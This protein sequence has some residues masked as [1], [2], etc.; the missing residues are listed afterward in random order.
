MALKI[1]T[2]SSKFPKMVVGDRGRVPTLPPIMRKL[3]AQ[4]LV[5]MPRGA[6]NTRPGG[7]GR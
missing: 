6:S 7:S 5:S 2:S 1:N 4:P 3:K